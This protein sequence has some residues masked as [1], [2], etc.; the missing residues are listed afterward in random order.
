MVRI[1]RKKKNKYERHAQRQQ[2]MAQALHG[3]GMYIFENISKGD[4][5]L[6]KNSAD[7]SK[8]PIP[9]G[10]KWKGDDYFVQLVKNRDAKIV[11]ILVSPQEQTMPEK[12]LVDQPDRVTT[13]GTVEQVLPTDIP[14]NEVGPSQ[15][16][17]KGEV[18]I[19]EDPLEG[20]DILLE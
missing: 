20:V 6:P 16:P 19:S 14:L 1:P 3:N 13:E 17:Q 9:P 18:L 12:L 5:W 4:L 2:H 15:I 8:G 10:G 11:Q 7:G